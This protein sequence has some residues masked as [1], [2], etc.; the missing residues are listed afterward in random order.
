MKLR[1]LILMLLPAPLMAQVSNPSIIPVSSAPSGSCSQSLPLELQTPNGTLYSC[2]SGTWAAISGGGGSPS[3]CTVETSGFSAT[4]GSCYI[5]NSASNITATLPSISTGAK[6][7]IQNNNAGTVTASFGSN[8]NCTVNNLTTSATTCPIANGSTGL[9]TT[10]GTSWYVAV[11]PTG[12]GSGSLVTSGLLAQYLF[13]DGSGTTLTD[14]SG[15]G[16]NCTITGA[17]WIQSLWLSF[18]GANN[19][20]TC[21]IGVWTGAKTIEIWFNPTPTSA[22]SQA[23]FE[24]SQQVL[25][26]GDTTTTP[27]IGTDGSH[28]SMFGFGVTSGYIGGGPSNTPEWVDTWSGNT[29]FGAVLGSPVQLYK[30]G[31]LETVPVL[32]ANLT[33]LPGTSLFRIGCNGEGGSYCTSHNYQG[34]I[35]AIR[36][37]SSALTPAQMA[38]DESAMESYLSSSKGLKFRDQVSYDTVPVALLGDSILAG[39][40]NTGTINVSSSILGALANYFP[41]LHVWN[42]GLQGDTASDMVTRMTS[43]IQPF[44][45]KFQGT[46]PVVIM[47]GGTNDILNSVAAATIYASQKSVCTAVHALNGKCVVATIIAA[48]R[49]TGPEE[50]IRETLNSLDQAGY[51]S[52]DLGADGFA[53]VGDDPIIGNSLN[54]TN[55]GYFADNVHTTPLT[56][57]LFYGPRL[58]LGVQSALGVKNTPLNLRITVPRGDLAGTS[59][60]TGTV[61]LLQLGTNQKICGATIKPVSPSIGGTVVAMTFSLGDS[62]GSATTYAPAYNVFQAPSNTVFQ[63]TDTLKSASYAG[64]TV[65]GTFA[66]TSDNVNAAFTNLVVDASTNTKVTSVSYAFVATDVGTDIYISGGTGWTVGSY[67]VQSVS[68]GA[69]TLDRSPAAVSTTGGDFLLG[70]VQVDLC[71][72]TSP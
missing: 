71:V 56:N 49:N 50:T 37:L 17:T 31:Q 34:A 25:M 2:Q 24:S 21:P 8:L 48:S 3:N 67:H 18:S 15:N 27:T 44:L 28:P 65:T 58:A 20:L 5:G 63:D 72:V 38:S 4:A 52:G 68:A 43:Q 1:W 32:A 54:E 45:Y 26:G 59:A 36:F 51:L 55:S 69:A 23:N 19:Y 13:T 66:S 30:L 47:G 12:V 10:D 22:I 46:T 16:N 40:P 70:E 33:S 53:D 64:G 9:A 42:F 57:Q 60:T 35:Y 6:I 39:G 62:L 7:S 41:A 29:S 14:S 11:T 61:N